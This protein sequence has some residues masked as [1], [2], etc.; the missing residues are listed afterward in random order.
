MRF[1]TVFGPSGYLHFCLFM[2]VSIRDS[3][4]AFDVSDLQSRLYAGRTRGIESGR[5]IY[6]FT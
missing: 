4:E 2:G 6:F 1:D 5:N 3:A